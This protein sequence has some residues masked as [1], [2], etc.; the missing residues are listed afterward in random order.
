MG[1]GIEANLHKFKV[2]GVIIENNCR[3]ILKEF[4]ERIIGK[5]ISIYV[6]RCSLSYSYLAT[7]YY[8]RKNVPPL[9]CVGSVALVMWCDD[10]I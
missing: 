3:R 6:R 7:F 8:S 4:L 9:L 10:L 2:N 5:V 1:W